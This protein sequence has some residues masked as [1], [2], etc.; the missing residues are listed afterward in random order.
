MDSEFVRLL[1]HVSNVAKNA[2]LPRCKVDDDVFDLER[3]LSSLSIAGP[4]NPAP[5][6]FRMRSATEFERHAKVGAAGELF[7]SS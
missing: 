5:D 7:V 4:S 1:N 2:T 3:H 6:W